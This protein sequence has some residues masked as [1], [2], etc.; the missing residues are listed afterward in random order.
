ML[1]PV[2]TAASIAEARSAI[3]P[4]T[5]HPASFAMARRT[6]TISVTPVEAVLIT[7]ACSAPV[8][9]SGIVLIGAR[10]PRDRL[11]TPRVQLGRNPIRAPHSGGSTPF[12]KIKQP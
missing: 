1:A 10:V 11:R 9:L 2:S 4:V 3:E 5:S 6:A 7:D 8:G 12:L